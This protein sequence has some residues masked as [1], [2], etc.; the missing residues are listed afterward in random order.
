[1]KKYIIVVIIV[2]AGLALSFK[3]L[4]ISSVTGETNIK[5]NITLADIE[6]LENSIIIDGLDM[7]SSEKPTDD[8]SGEILFDNSF[9][10]TGLQNV[11]DDLTKTNEKKPQVKTITSHNEILK[12][13]SNEKPGVKKSEIKKV[14]KV[15]TID[16]LRKKDKRWHLSEHVIKKGENLWKIAKQYDTNH[17]YIIMINNI[18]EPKKLLPGKV[19]Q[20]PNRQGIEY[21][22]KKG[23][24]VYRISSQFNIE[25]EKILSHNDIKNGTIYYGNELFIPDAK[26]PVRKPENANPVAKQ[27]QNKETVHNRVMAF[28]WP[29]KGRITSSFGKR[30]DPFTKKKKFHCGIDISC[31]EGTPVK[32]SYD[33]RVIYSDWKDGYGK[34]VIIKHDKGYITVYAHNRENIVNVGD[35]VKKGTVVAYSGM[36]GAVTGAHLHYEIRK[37]LAPLNPMKLLK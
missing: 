6:N 15:I 34:V 13:R 3:N 24:T 14:S 4:N 8:F 12:K 1:M 22:I 10:D 21:N 32:A 35:E 16:S 36:T 33:G 25:K 31:N 29:V 20:V 11:N 26:Y 18:D 5:K 7:T 2:A 23:D 30:T 17:R 37:Y 19:I 9:D 27:N 28:A